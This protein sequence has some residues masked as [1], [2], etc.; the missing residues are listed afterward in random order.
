MDVLCYLESGGGVTDFQ[1]HAGR[2][3]R[4][5]LILFDTKIS[6]LL[7]L[8][9]RAIGNIGVAVFSMYVTRDKSDGSHRDSHNFT[10]TLQLEHKDI[11]C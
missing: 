4:I 2:L 11:N 10:W 3:V 1:P 8:L 5:V 7:L 9:F 6:K